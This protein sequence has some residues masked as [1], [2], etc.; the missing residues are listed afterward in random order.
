[1]VPASPKA[2]RKD[3]EFDLDVRVDTVIRHG[4]V[5]AGLKPTDQ[6]CPE[7]PTNITCHVQGGCI[8]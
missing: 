4:L 3:A 6:G 7:S 2:P 5:E 8:E 1:M